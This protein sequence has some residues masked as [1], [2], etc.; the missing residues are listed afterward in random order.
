MLNQV[1]VL[2]IKV[3]EMKESLSFYTEVFDFT[4]SKKYSEKIVSLVHK[5]IPIVLEE[6]NSINLSDSKSVLLGISSKNIGHD[7][8]LLKN[9]GAN[10]LFDE[11]EPCPPGLYFIVE[12]P[13]GNQLEV[14]EFTNEEQ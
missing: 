9:R 7:F 12:D 5:N 11:P 4:V 1:C 14:V 8:K 10:V 13:S 6:D 2:T 3:K